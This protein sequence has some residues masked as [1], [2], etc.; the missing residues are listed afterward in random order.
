MDMILA[1]H[2]E[3]AVERI[4]QHQVVLVPQDTTAL[5]Y[6]LPMTEGLGPINNKTDKTIGLILH[7]TLAFTEQGTPLGLVDA[8][9]WARDPEDLRQVGPAQET[10]D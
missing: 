6:T 8:Q 4:R 1:P 9:I 3:A 2:L 5:T 7:D 10:A